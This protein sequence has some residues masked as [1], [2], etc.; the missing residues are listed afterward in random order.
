M[1][2]YIRSVPV[3]SGN[4]SLRHR[5]QTGSGAHPA[6]Y[7][8]GTGGSFHGGIAAGAWSWPLTSIKCRGKRMSGAM[9]PLPQY[10]FIAWCLVKHRGNFTFTFFTY[11]VRTRHRQRNEFLGEIKTNIKE[12]KPCL[13][14]QHFLIVC[15]QYGKV[16]RA[17]YGE[18]LSPA[19]EQGTEI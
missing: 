14:V 1:W 8:M 15:Q 5:V 19:T 13:S 4:F 7:P 9:L 6:S 12:R 16:V 17:H 18:K 3:E 2:R 10:G 11:S